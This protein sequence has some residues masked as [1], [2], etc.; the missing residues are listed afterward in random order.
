MR[1]Q[2]WVTMAGM[3]GWYSL[4][5]RGCLP[6]RCR[7]NSCFNSENRAENEIIFA[8]GNSDSNNLLFKASYASNSWNSQDKREVRPPLGSRSATALRRDEPALVSASI[9]HDSDDND[10]NLAIISSPR[11]HKDQQEA[12]L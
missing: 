12:P 5:A 7:S 2:I 1:E 8:A 4:R 6:L 3:A 9:D 10:T 11:K